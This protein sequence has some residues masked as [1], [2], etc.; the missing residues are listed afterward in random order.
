MVGVKMR[1][2]KKILGA[3]VIFLA[4]C[5]L[6]LT[7]VNAYALNFAEDGENEKLRIQIYEQKAEKA[8]IA[9]QMQVEKQ[10]IEKQNAI[11]VEKIKR[12]AVEKQQINLNSLNNRKPFFINMIALFIFVICG[13]ALY[14]NRLIRKAIK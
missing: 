13:I 8:A 6:I 4:G 2:L 5:F 7:Y 12:E 14:L 10:K 1:I 9:K 11:L 3:H